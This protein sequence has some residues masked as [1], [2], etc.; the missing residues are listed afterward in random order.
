M[1]CE[2]VSLI[3]RVEAMVQCK[4]GTFDE[5]GVLPY[6]LDHYNICNTACA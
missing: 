6:L 5:A 3:I 2:C 1:L 4:R